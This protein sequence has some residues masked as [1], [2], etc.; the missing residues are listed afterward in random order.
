MM[1]GSG[2]VSMPRSPEKG[3]RPKHHRGFGVTLVDIGEQAGGEAD[4]EAGTVRLGLW[5]LARARQGEGRHHQPQDHRSPSRPARLGPCVGLIGERREFM[6]RAPPFFRSSHE[7]G[8]FRQKGAGGR[9]K[10][11]TR[12]PRRWRRIDK[13]PRICFPL[14]VP[15]R[16]ATH[17]SPP[18]DSI[19]FATKR[20]GT[21]PRRADGGHQFCLP[22][23]GRVG[24]HGTRSGP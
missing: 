1:L 21:T 2:S 14:N 5:F 13:S 7:P 10:V 12:S 19:H 22:I 16:F 20:V 9:R 8:M 23:S 3:L 18:G 17:R 6:G 15:A 24:H 11:A 4:A